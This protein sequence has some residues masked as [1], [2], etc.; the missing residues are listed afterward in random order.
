MDGSSSLSAHLLSTLHSKNIWFLFQIRATSR[1]GALP[2]SWINNNTLGLNL[3]LTWEWKK[4]YLALTQLG[5]HLTNSP[6][7]PHWSRGDKSGQITAKNI[8]VAIANANWPNNISGWK[9]TFW[10]WRIPQKINIFFW[11]LTKNKLNTWDNLLRKGWSGPNI[12]C[13]CH[14]DSESID[15]LFI[16]CQF[17]KQV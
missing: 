7:T 12:C 16:K 17:T 11:L 8:Y 5:I 13:L 6:D 15:H 9:N 4:L 3:D 14:L 1:S 10:A 2:D